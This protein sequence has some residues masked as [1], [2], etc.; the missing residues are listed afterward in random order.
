MTKRPIEASSE[1][2]AVAHAIKRQT[3]TALTA[4][5]RP[6]RTNAKKVGREFTITLDVV[7]Q[8]AEAQGFR[9]AITGIPF[10]SAH[11]GASRTNPFRPSIDRIDNLRGYEPDNIR[12]VVF[13]VNVAC[14][15]WGEKVFSTVAE[16]YH[17]R[18]VVPR[19]RMR[20]KRAKQKQESQE[21]NDLNAHLQTRKQL[22]DAAK[23]LRGTNPAAANRCLV[24]RQQLRAH[25]HSVPSMQPV[26]ARIIEQNRTALAELTA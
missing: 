5:F 4:T 6:I 9:C 20:A 23:G 25:R 8:K 13:A 1:S 24:I 11:P 22:A 14:L 7:L 18:K 2:R 19:L 16:A 21:M 26:V 17:S 3:E 12:I 10:F 15:D